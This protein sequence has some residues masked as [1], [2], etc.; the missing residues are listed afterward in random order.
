MICAFMAAGA[1]ASVLS[2]TML[3][4]T[5]AQVAAADS[6]LCSKVN[7]RFALSADISGEWVGPDA[8]EKSQYLVTRVLIRK[9]GL[10]KGVE[11]RFAEP[12]ASFGIT[13][14][15]WAVWSPDEEFVAL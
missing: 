14:A 4:L 13:G 15:C 2:L 3:L 7:S 12:V 5:R 11:Y 9:T 6:L 8:D 1:R 10:S